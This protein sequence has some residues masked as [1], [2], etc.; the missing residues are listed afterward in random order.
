MWGER[1]KH[2]RTVR[3]GICRLCWVKQ[4]HHEKPSRAGGIKPALQL[5]Q[6]WAEIREGRGREL[7]QAEGSPISGPVGCRGGRRISLVVPQDGSRT[8]RAGK[9][10]PV[11]RTHSSH[12]PGI[13]GPQGSLWSVEAAWTSYPR[14]AIFPAEWGW[15]QQETGLFC[16]VGDSLKDAWDHWAGITGQELWTG[17]EESWFLAL[18]WPSPGY[19]W[20]I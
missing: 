6:A 3:G 17:R 14:W 12:V 9:H 19:P 16:P 10:T 5:N 13:Q 7:G 20:Q 8:G 2:F 1:T 11:I 18:F 15:S 4:K